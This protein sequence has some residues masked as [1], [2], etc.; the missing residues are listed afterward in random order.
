M[1]TTRRFSRLPKLSRIGVFDPPP[2]DFIA[3][4]AGDS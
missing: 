4:K 1:S 3:M 2:D